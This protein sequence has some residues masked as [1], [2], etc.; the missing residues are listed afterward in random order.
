MNTSESRDDLILSSFVVGPMH[1]NCTIVA[2]PESRLG[3]VVD[4]G[5]DAERI[6]REIEGLAVSVEAI[7]LTHVH[8]DHVIALGE[9]QQRTAAPCYLHKGDRFLW[10]R[11]EAQFSRSGFSF[12]PGT[13][14]PRWLSDGDRLPCC[15]GAVLHTPGHTPGSVCLWFEEHKLLIS[16]DTLFHRGIGRTDIAG[17]SFKHLEKSIVESLFTLDE[18]TEVITGHGP[19]T[20]IGDE[21]RMNPFFGEVMR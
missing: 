11:L 2:D 10:D 3:M 1:S 21:I 6:L 7:I 16:G 15:N 9:V 19:N 17:G 12:I 18:Q 13:V 20:S 8:I 4:P 5:G 14:P